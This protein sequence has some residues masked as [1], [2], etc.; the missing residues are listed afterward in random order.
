MGPILR[1]P[2]HFLQNTWGCSTFLTASVLPRTTPTLYASSVSCL[3]DSRCYFSP[4]YFCCLNATKMKLLY[5]CLFGTVVSIL[6]IE[7]QKWTF[8][9]VF[10]QCCTVIFQVYVLKWTLLTHILR[11][12]FYSTGSPKVGRGYTCCSRWC[13]SGTTCCCCNWDLQCL[14]L[15]KNKMEKVVPR[16]VTH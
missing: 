6:C 5:W 15:F 8:E 12:W 10:N 11:A 13:A 14:N 4:R 7:R 2:E 16:C 3:A 9:L 1:L